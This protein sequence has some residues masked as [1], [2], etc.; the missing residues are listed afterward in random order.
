MSVHEA[1]PAAFKAEAKAALAKPQLKV[2]LDR[3]T[4]LLQGRCIEVMA[5]FPEFQTA[6]D[7]G[8]AIKDHTL[9]YLDHYLEEF[10]AA[11]K[12]S[13]TEVHW[14]ST[15][16]E[17]TRICVEI[18]QRRGAKSA[19]RV[20]SMLGEE[21]GLPKAL[22]DAGIERVETDLAEHIIQLADERPS[23]IV[24]PAL[25]KTQEE[26]ADLF[27]KNHG[28]P[29]ASDDVE[30]LVASARHE[31]RDKYVSADVGISGA[32]FLIAETGAIVT[33]TNEGNAELTTALPPC[34]IVTVG[35]EKLVPN[36]EHASLFLRLLARSALGSEFTQYV[37]FYNGPKRPGDH[38][39]PEEMHIVLVDNRRTQMLA[40]DMREMLRCIRCGACMNHCPVYG[41][42]GGHPYG[43]TYPGPMGAV[44]TPALTSLEEAG[45]LPNAC[46]LNGR[47][48]EVCPVK[49]PLTDMMRSMRERQWRERMVKPRA[50]LAIQAWAFAAKRPWLYRT[51]TRIAV[52]AMRLF[53]GKHGRIQSLPLAGGWTGSRDMTVP[54]TS[55]FMAQWKAGRRR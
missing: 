32:N 54:E 21:I 38:D 45:D 26:V 9:K 20:K 41:A 44:L 18:C 17:A 16:E 48:Q 12:A 4:N 46:T 40:G 2:A 36:Q 33:V 29:R 50:C 34:H 3:A 5:E 22:A 31:L 23:H 6:R 37:T 28:A 42:V 10:E 8:A 53:R 51:G 52:K 25:H 55:T 39:G 1:T 14:A 11:A 30:D 24:I 19:T 13:G 15:P 43:G 7:Q 35:I 27:T 49:I 47:C